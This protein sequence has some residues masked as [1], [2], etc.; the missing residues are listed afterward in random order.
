MT[1]SLR[2]DL[3]A[4]LIRSALALTLCGAVVTYVVALRFADETYDQWLLDSAR[5]LAQQVEVENGAVHLDLP[6]PALQ[7]LVWDAY[8]KV[9]FRVD[10]SRAVRSS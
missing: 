9:I 5:S 6:A 2:R 4:R 3:L 8:D 7:L 1:T 10:S